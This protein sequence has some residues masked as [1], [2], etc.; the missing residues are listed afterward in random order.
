MLHM[1]SVDLI[2][3]LLY[4]SFSIRDMAH[5]RQGNIDHSALAGVVLHVSAKHHGIYL[6]P[7]PSNDPH[8]PLLWPRWLKVLALCTTAFFN[9]T[10]NFA[11]AGPSVATT[12]IQAQFMKSASEVNGLLTVCSSATKIHI[13][14]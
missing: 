12:L 9:F 7:P 4:H 6:W 5:L 11:A 1:S 13:F 14:I 8:D 10:S 2:L 3:K